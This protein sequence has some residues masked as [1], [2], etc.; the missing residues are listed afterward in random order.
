MI[1]SRKL[2]TNCARWRHGVGKSTKG[3]EKQTESR[4]RNSH[5]RPLYSVD[6]FRRIP[7]SARRKL[8]DTNSIQYKYREFDIP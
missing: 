7:K 3:G 6:R 2:K 5:F 1:T 4:T 8:D